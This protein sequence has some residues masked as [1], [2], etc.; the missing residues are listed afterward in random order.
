VIP[1]KR[2][3]DHKTSGVKVLRYMQKTQ[4]HKIVQLISW[5]CSECKLQVC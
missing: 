1:E 4:Q 3:K 5:Q 2:T